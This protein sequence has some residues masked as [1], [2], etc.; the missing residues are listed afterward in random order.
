MYK[1]ILILPVL[2]LTFGFIFSAT[3]SSKT[4][5]AP[6]DVLTG[7]CQGTAASAS[8]SCQDDSTTATSNPIYGPNGILTEAIQILA[9]VVGIV[10]IVMILIS[11]LRMITS[12]GDSNAVNSARSAILYSLIGVA[13]A[14]SA[15]IIVVFVLGK[16]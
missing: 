4:F 1:K 10:S 14:V 13:I 15:Q 5:A 7:P 3:V 12:G 8:S 6:V 2:I 11:G 9:W 16:V